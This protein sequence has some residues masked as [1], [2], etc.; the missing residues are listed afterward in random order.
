MRQ[1]YTGVIF[2]AVLAVSLLGASGITRVEWPRLAVDG[3]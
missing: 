2:A 3:S 1:L